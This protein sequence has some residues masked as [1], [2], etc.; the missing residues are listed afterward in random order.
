M[1]K[2]MDENFLLHSETAIKLYHD[3]AKNMPIFD[4]HNHLSAKEIYEDNNYEN[5]AKVWLS[6]DHYKWRLMRSNGVKEEFITGDEADYDKFFAYARTI[7][8]AIGNPLYHWSH[9]ELQRYFGIDTPLCE[10]NAS[11]IYAKCNETLKQKDMSPR[12]IILRSNVKAMCTTDDPKDDLQY[13]RLL[14]EEGFECL[15]LP[16]FRPDNLVHIERPG[17]ADYMCS[18]KQLGYVISSLKDLLCFLSSRIEYFHS[19]GCRLSDHALDVV[20]YAPSTQ[21]EVE[22]IFKKVLQ[23]T[24]LTL[25][26]VKKY[27]GFILNFLGKEYNKRNWVQQY[28]IGAMRNNSSKMFMQLGADTGFDS[29]C[30]ANIAQELSQLMDSMDKTSAL[31]KTILYCLNPAD[32]A[33]L[34]SMLGNFQGGGVAGKIQFGSA[35]WFSDT[36]HG[37]INQMRELAAMG[38][39]SQF[40]GMLT[41]SRSLLSFPRHEYFRRILCGELATLVENGE[42]PENY[43]ILEKIVENICYNNISRYIQIN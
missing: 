36:K 1:K 32:N 14:A 22:I 34:A 27:K 25:Q 3:Y 4:Y 6:G 29:I 21:Q 12:S 33:V 7:S 20:M 40:V 37:M 8:Y 31:P 9:L 15:V 16:T 26:E 43:E 28:H 38:M 13:H 10:A 41:D 2:F 24:S 23:K 5:I 42:Y 19:S 39:L 35:W 11:E 30:D 18:L 17:F